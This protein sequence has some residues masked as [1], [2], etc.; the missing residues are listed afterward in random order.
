ME[1]KSYYPTVSSLLLVLVT[2]FLPPN[3]RVG[4][5]LLFLGGCCNRSL[6]CSIASSFSDSLAALMSRLPRKLLLMELVALCETPDMG[7]C[8]GVVKG[9]VGGWVEFAAVTS[10]TE[11]R[12]GV[13]LFMTDAAD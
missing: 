11:P 3:T 12:V 2:P 13:G 5:I 6:F 10:G 7:V 1:T 4:A 9:R 8:G